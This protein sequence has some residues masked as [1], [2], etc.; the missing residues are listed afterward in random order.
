MKNCELR[1]IE[2]TRGTIL[3]QSRIGPT[4]LRGV[5]VRG[6][7]RLLLNPRAANKII[8]YI[9]KIVNVST[10]TFFIDL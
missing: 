5:I 3:T 6:L 1:K 7:E 4:N 8:V 9:S 10:Y 2:K